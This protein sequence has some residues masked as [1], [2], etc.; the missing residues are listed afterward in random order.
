MDN[1]ISTRVSTGEY[2][3][4][5]V[6]PFQIKVSLGS[7]KKWRIGIWKEGHWVYALRQ[8]DTKEKAMIAAQVYLEDRIMDTICCAEK[9]R[10]NGGQSQSQ[11]GEYKMDRKMALNILG[12]KENDTPEMIKKKH[13]KL[14]SKVHPDMGGNTFLMV[15]V[16]IA[17]DILLGGR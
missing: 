8:F 1:I 9:W 17:K 15:Q 14:A 3:V 4:K 6:Y 7:N 16:N 11:I 13:R 5:A 2:N 12:V 10:Q